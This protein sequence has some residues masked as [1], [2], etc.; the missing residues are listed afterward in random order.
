MIKLLRRF[1]ASEDGATALE[2]V[3]IG[4]LISVA[5]VTGAISLGDSIG[6][7]FGDTSVQVG[8]ALD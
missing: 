3:L 4:G 1:W 6:N 8:T 5:V 7:S 2:Y